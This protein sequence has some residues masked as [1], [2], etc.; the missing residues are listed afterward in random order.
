MR[1]TSSHTKNR[2]SHHGLKK[3]ATTKCENCGKIKTPHRVCSNCGTYNKRPVLDVLKKL[4]KKEK[5][6]KEKELAE[7]EKGKKELSPEELSK[8]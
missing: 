5:K 3:V 4:T 6:N 7:Q 2:R 1:H 8:K